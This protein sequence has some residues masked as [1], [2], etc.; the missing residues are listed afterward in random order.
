M[1]SGP[2]AAVA[3]KRFGKGSHKGT[4]V[5]SEDFNLTTTW[6][7]HFLMTYDPN[8]KTYRTCYIDE[9]NTTTSGLSH[10]FSDYQATR[11]QVR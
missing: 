2:C 6:E 4:I 8:V 10:G 7:A 5:L 1:H 3:N 9:S 11:I